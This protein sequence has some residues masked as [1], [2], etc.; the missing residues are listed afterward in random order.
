MPSNVL[1]LRITPA[2]RERLERGRT[3]G[4][5]NSWGAP[6]M[7]DYVIAL[8]DPLLPQ[9]APPERVTRKELPHG[10]QLVLPD[11]RRVVL[12]DPAAAAKPPRK[13]KRARKPARGK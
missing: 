13:A 9:L 7:Q 4:Y 5:T 6:S 2:F 1:Y 3:A 12:E 10:A 8:L 11:G